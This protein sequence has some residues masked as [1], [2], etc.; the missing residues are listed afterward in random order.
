MYGIELETSSICRAIERSTAIV[1]FDMNCRVIGANDNFLTLFG[2]DF[3]DIELRPHNLFCEP[4]LAGT[5]D[6]AAFWDRLRAGQ[7]DT[8]VYR[9]QDR[10]GRLIWIRGSYNPIFDDDGVQIGI[11]KF[12]TDISAEQEAIAARED[13]EQR[14]SRQERDRRASIERVLGEVSGIVDAIDGIARQTNLKALN[15]SIEA[16]RAGEAGRGF[17]VVAVEV[18]KLALD[19]QNATR[20]ARAVISG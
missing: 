13:A 18:K 15:A 9:R 12:A 4:G 16:A 1:S 5:A 2:Y 3:A 7:F 11:I 8:G 20:D 14:L 19:T 17:S 6:Y 10:H